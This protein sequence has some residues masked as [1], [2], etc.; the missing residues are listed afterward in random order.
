[1]TS[2]QVKNSYNLTWLS[3]QSST[4]L[5]IAVFCPLLQHM[6]FLLYFVSSENQIFIFIKQQK[7]TFSAALI[8]L[9]HYAE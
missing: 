8:Y 5:I 4:L 9:S 6:L 3:S 2:S 7:S 1:V